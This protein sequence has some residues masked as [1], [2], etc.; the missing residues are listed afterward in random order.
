M[1]SIEE[2]EEDGIRLTTRDPAVAERLIIERRRERLRE[3]IAACPGHVAVTESEPRSFSH[4]VA[5]PPFTHE[6]PAA[7]GNIWFVETCR[8]GAIRD[9]LQN[10]RH[11]E[12]SPWRAPEA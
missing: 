7:H 10:Q 6:N 1:R 12:V 9:V 3:R 4:S 2:R 11:T 8:C 5:R